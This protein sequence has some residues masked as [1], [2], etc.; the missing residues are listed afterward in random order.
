MGQKKNKSLRERVLEKWKLGDGALAHRGL[1]RMLDSTI[2]ELNSMTLYTACCENG[3]H[4]ETTYVTT[5]RGHNVAVY[6]VY[7]EAWEA[8]RELAERNSGSPHVEEFR[9]MLK[10]KE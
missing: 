7:E 5:N 6:D 1:I 10:E 8:A 3:Y 2:A 9:T 4:G